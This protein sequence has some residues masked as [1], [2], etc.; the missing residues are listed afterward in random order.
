MERE[1]EGGWR[2]AA[3]G[4]GRWRVDGDAGEWLRDG[5]GVLV[6][7]GELG[8]HPWWRGDCTSWEGVE[9]WRSWW[10]SSSSRSFSRSFLC[11]ILVHLHL[12]NWTGKWKKS[13]GVALNSSGERS[14]SARSSSL[15][16]LDSFW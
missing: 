5:D 2:S 1:L 10:R 8:A 7:L 12:S 11:L 13:S 3:W 15:S 9:C 6:R 4:V 14:R 16:K